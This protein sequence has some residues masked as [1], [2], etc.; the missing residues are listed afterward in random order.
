MLREAFSLVAQSRR[1]GR[2][3]RVLEPFS[4][5]PASYGDNAIEKG[6]IA[7]EAYRDASFYLDQ[8]GVVGRGGEE[9]SP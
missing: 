6:R 1:C 3:A 5:S 8:P 2:N 4:E 9:I 7:F